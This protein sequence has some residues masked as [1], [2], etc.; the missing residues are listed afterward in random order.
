MRTSEKSFRGLGTHPSPFPFLLPAVPG[1]ATLGK[2][3]NGMKGGC[4]LDDHA[5]AT[6]PLG[7]LHLHEVRTEFYLPKLPLLSV[8]RH[9]TAR[10][11]LAD[12]ELKRDTTEMFL[13]DS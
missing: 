9:L 12:T 5:A 13:S 3:L 6:E 2:R 1:A 10:S 4:I 7:C 8:F 11:N